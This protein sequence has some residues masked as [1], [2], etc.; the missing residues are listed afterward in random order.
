MSPDDDGEAVAD[1]PEGA[2]DDEHAVTCFFCVA[3]NSL[4]LEIADA[5]EEPYFFVRQS[6]IGGDTGTAVETCGATVSPSATAMTMNENFLRIATPI[7]EALID[8]R[9]RA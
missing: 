2:V 6:L 3:F 7:L 1:P 8:L 5:T 4:A 9:C